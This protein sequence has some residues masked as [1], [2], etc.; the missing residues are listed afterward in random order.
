MRKSIVAGLLILVALLHVNGN[1]P[2]QENTAS[3]KIRSWLVEELNNSRKQLSLSLLQFNN[4]SQLKEHYHEARKHYK[5]TEFFVEYR[6]FREA[7][8]FINGPLVPKVDLDLSSQAYS[9]QGF[10]RIEELLFKTSGIP[11]TI[12]LRNEYTLL[13]AQL[14]QISHYYQQIKISDDQL[15][16]MCQ[17]ELFRIGAMNLS[18]YDATLSQTNVQEAV[19]CMEGIESVLNAFTF[20]VNQNE[21]I[22][23][24]YKRLMKEV[25]RSKKYLLKN[26]DYNTFDR[27]TFLTSCIQP[28]NKL[29][30]HFHNLSGLAWN[31]RTQALRLQ[32]GFL[33]GAE[34]FDAQYFAFSYPEV[35]DIRLLAEL[36]KLLFFDPVLSGNHQ[37]ACASC[38]Q[39]SKAFTDG[40]SKSLAFGNMNP[41]TRN[42]PTLLNVIYQKAF[43]YDG[44]AHEL[45]SQIMDV[46]HNQ[47][48]MQ[49]DLPMIAGRLRQSSE[50][51]K[52]FKQAFKGSSDSTITTHAILKA[53]SEYEKTLLSM[54]SRFDQ[55]LH[56][57]KQ[58]LTARE[59]NG[60]NLFAGKALCGSC[61]FFPLF[62]GTVPPFYRESEYEVLGTPADAS[63]LAPDT[64]PGRYSVT[65]IPEQKA[66]FKTPTVRNIALTGPYMHN[67]IYN[68][69]EEVIEFYHKGGGAG[70]NYEVPNQTLPFDS[71]QL[72][73]KEK[74]DLV[75]FLRTLTD[76][77]GLTRKPS[78]L[79]A[80]ENDPALNKRVI[81]GTY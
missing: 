45:E 72:S 18:G 60:Y 74:A 7:K 68:T 4:V 37:R 71:L 54:N 69:L 26:T 19:W 57:A 22:K 2:F 5:H 11:D 44:R 33:F 8:Y 81:G 1:L 9:P 66:A 21:S 20:Y 50:Y 80:F 73:P 6:S 49:S 16:E 36:G 63:N 38:H 10:Q 40:L 58:A 67:G 30:V 3:E 59:V 41:L 31:E 48:E 32:Q 61:H 34:S 42:A 27:L 13:E 23:R 56:G 65:H 64:D 25:A 78:R 75:L 14:A 47:N 29:L 70:F 51:R 46:V 62:N 12:A 17:L 76:T 39:P 53:I 28:L 15:L 77:V 35:T 79:P 52:L 43:F 24:T 55:Y